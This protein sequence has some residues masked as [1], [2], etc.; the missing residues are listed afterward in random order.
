[1]LGNLGYGLPS[2]GDHDVPQ[3]VPVEVALH[4]GFVD[5]LVQDAEANAEPLEK[6][7]DIVAI[8]R[9]S[10][11]PG[12]EEGGQGL[13]AV[14]RD[15]GLHIAVD[16]VARMAQVYRVAEI[17]LARGGSDACVIASLLRGVVSGLGARA[18]LVHTPLPRLVEIVH[19]VLSIGPTEP[20]LA[21]FLS[22]CK[23]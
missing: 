8:D 21:F 17:D 23:S 14:G 10:L 19:L 9:E 22:P 1:M 3:E 20:A 13:H 2:L 15:R 4:D 12:R 11:A 6:L 7:A 5:R 16:A 18:L